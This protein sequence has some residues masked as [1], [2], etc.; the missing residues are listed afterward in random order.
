[1]KALT[2]VLAFGLTGCL[3]DAAVVPVTPANSA[4]VSTCQAAA[5]DHNALVVGDYIVAAGGVTSG[6][7]AA[8]L[9]AS[10]VSGKTD[11]AV[12]GAVL[13]GVSGLATALVGL[14]TNSFN[15][16][17]CTQVVGPLPASPFGAT[18]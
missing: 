12:S 9:P 18:K 15:D 14:T 2:I 3:N 10:N 8:A 5:A 11:L 16:N 6:I 1:V 13:A 7:V 17:Q 4:Q